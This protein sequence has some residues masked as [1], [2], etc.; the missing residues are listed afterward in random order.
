MMKVNVIWGL[1]LSSHRPVPPLTLLLHQASLHQRAAQHRWDA[2][3]SKFGYL[4]TGQRAAFAKIALSLTQSLYFSSSFYTS[5]QNSK[6]LLHSISWALSGSRLPP[7]MCFSAWS[8]SPSP[9]PHLFD[10]IG[11]DQ[12]EKGGPTICNS[13]LPRLICLRCFALGER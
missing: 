9:L 11:R 13:S 6:Q 8:S 1:V 3:H 10:I 5:T 12:W 4:E 7:L 2:H